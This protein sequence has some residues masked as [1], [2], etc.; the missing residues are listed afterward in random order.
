MITKLFFSKSLLIVLA[1]FSFNITQAQ[2]CTPYNWD[3]TEGDLILNVL[4]AGIDNDSDCGSNGYSD[5][6]VDVNPAEVIA[7]ESYSLGVKVGGGWQYETVGYWIDFDNSETFDAT[8]FFMLGTG[9]DSVVEG[10]IDIPENIAEGTYRIRISVVAA[11]IPAEGPC[12]DGQQFFG[13]FEDYLIN[14][15]PV[16]HTPNFDFSKSIVLIK[17]DEGL[18]ISA[19]SS[20]AQIEIYDLTGKIITTRRNLNTHNLSLPLSIA[21]QILLVKIQSIEGYNTVKKMIF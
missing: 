9:S 11:P 20:I 2:Y 19:N 13:E 14:V 8:E 16:L 4:F 18:N 12:L 15:S 5:F 10:E 21:N 7:G 17:T 6:T 3:C 1:L